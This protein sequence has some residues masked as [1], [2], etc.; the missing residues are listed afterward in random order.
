M[1]LGF[2]GERAAMNKL[3]ENIDNGTVNLAAFIAAAGPGPPGVSTISQIRAW[4]Y[5]SYLASDHAEMLETFTRYV[6]ISKRPVHERLPLY[7]QVPVPPNDAAHTLSRLILPAC[8]KIAEADVRA[9][10][11]LRSAVAGIACERFR[12]AAGRWPTDLAEIPKD[13]LP[14]V[15]LDA[16]DGKPIRYRRTADGVVVYSVGPDLQDDG[17]AVT[18]KYGQTAELA[19]AAEALV[20]GVVRKNPGRPGEDYGFRLWDPKHRKAAPL[21]PDGDGP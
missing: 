2:R 9:K 17:G 1:V 8:V 14:E 12:R 6:E 5:R 20:S 11:E 21:P 18:R 15:P 10:A 19:A 13:I 4:R 7:K 3:F 16:Y